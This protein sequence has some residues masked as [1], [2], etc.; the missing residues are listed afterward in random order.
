MRRFAWLVI[1]CLGSVCCG[2]AAPGPTA[3]ETVTTPPAPGPSLPP[4]LGGAQPGT[5]SGTFNG[6]IRATD[7][8]C[9]SH[10]TFGDHQ[11][12]PCHRY[13]PFDLPVFGQMLIQL[14]WPQPSPNDVEFEVWR[15]GLH[16]TES[17]D[18]FSA[19]DSIA[20]GTPAG[21]YEV[22]VVYLGSTSKN[23]RLRVAFTG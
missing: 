13:G 18:E 15:N 1:L 11:G 17:G 21:S 4:L 14:S 2:E 6:V 9:A 20:G 10:R 5:A 12:K 8:P 7:V 19:F 3:P 23:Y 22:R 16:Y